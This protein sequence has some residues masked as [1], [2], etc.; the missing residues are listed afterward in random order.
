MSLV[1]FSYAEEDQKLATEISD[2]LLKKN[3]LSWCFTRDSILGVEYTDQIPDAMTKANLVVLLISKHSIASP[4]VK[5]EIQLSH[6]KRLSI[7]PILIGM[8]SAEYQNQIPT[9][10]EGIL[11]T[12][13]FGNADYSTTNEL[14]DRILKTI[15]TLKPLPSPPGMPVIGDWPSDGLKINIEL[16]K[17]VLFCTPEITRFLESG[18]QFFVSANKGMGKTLLLRYK[19]AKLMKEY[20]SHQSHSHHTTVCFAPE[21]SPYVDM[22]EGSIPGLKD[23][24]IKLLSDIRSS[25]RIWSF[26]LRLSAISYFPEIAQQLDQVELRNLTNQSANFLVKPRVNP[27]DIFCSLLS[28][29]PTRLNKLLDQFELQLSYLYQQI[30]SGIF[31]FIDSIDFAVA[32]LDRKAWTYT[33]A[34][35][36]EAAWSA[37]GA[38]NHVKIYTSIREEA[39]INYESDAKAN[40]HTTILPLRYSIKQLQGL[41][42]RLCKV[43]ELLPNFKAFVGVHEIANMTGQTPED[44]FRY[45]HRHTIGR[46]RDLVLICHQLSKSRPELDQ[47]QFQKIVMESSSRSVLR[48]IFKEMSIF[49]D[50]LLDENERQ[51][52]F[53][54]ISQNI[55]TR[56]MIEEIC[57]KYNGLEETHYNAVNKSEVQIFHPFCELYNCGLIGYVQ[58]DNKHQHAI[59][60]FKQPDDV[61]NFSISCLPAAKYYVLHPSLSSLINTARL[62]EFL[63]YPFITVGHQCRWYSWYDQLIESLKYL[64]MIQG[65][66][67]YQQSLQELSF[68][69]CQL[70]AGLKVDLTELEKIASLLELVQDDAFLA[71]SEFIEAIP[72]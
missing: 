42:D 7:V 24:H 54:M 9:S 15:N 28:L 26:A 49:L 30:H 63:R 40:I 45:M 62:N 32:H 68:V 11:T 51:R 43:Y 17:S 69:I 5:K 27:T 16:L 41:I 34:G 72:Q 47:D 67:L 66:Q 4:E 18:N 8:T 71:M 1:F 2:H 19:R 37:M 70:H 22:I 38:N 46:P 3:V 6:I 57:C 55:L 65:H 21:N 52:F 23:G 44:S 12:T 53:R 14:A 58:W 10:W 13:V 56:Q 29:T 48:P 64:N 50:A 31:L 61:M 60:Y 20:T 35:L 59:Q 39:F 36:I 33:Q 25:K